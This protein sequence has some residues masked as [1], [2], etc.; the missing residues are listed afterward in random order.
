MGLKPFKIA[1]D[2]EALELK[3]DSPKHRGEKP[4]V[5]FDGGS[6][7]ANLTLAVTTGWRAYFQ[8]PGFAPNALIGMRRSGLVAQRSR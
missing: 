3:C 6:R 2:R 1:D 8:E 7:A 4:T 5:W